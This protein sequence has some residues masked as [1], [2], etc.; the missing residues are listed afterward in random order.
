MTTFSF[1]VFT[2]N[3]RGNVEKLYKVE[4]ALLSCRPGPRRSGSVAQWPCPSKPRQ[5]FSQFEPRST[6]TVDRVEGVYLSSQQ[7]IHCNYMYVMVL[8]WK[9]VGV[10]APPTLASQG[11]FF[12]HDG[13]Y[14]RNRRSPLCVL[15][16]SNRWRRTKNSFLSIGIYPRMCSA[17]FFQV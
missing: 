14:A 16:G 6:Y 11:W 5:L 8:G 1:G 2:V 9:G 10:R 7:R 4:A 3:W 12:H 13:M 15:C 17:A